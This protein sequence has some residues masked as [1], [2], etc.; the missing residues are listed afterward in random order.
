MYSQ[1]IHSVEKQKWTETSIKEYS[2]RLMENNVPVIFDVEHLRRLIKI[3]KNVFYNILFKIDYQYHEIDIPK[4]RL[5][6]FMTLSQVF[7]VTNVEF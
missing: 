5:G 4:K 2:S 6:E 3:K 7:R 1:D